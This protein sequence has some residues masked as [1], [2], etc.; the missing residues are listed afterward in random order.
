MRN[1]RKIKLT[2]KVFHVRQQKNQLGIEAREEVNHEKTNAERIVGDYK[3]SKERQSTSYLAI[4]YT[5]LIFAVSFA[6]IATQTLIP[7][8]DNFLNPEYWWEIIILKACVYLLLRIVLVTA[9]EAY[10]IFQIEQIMTI[11]WHFKLYVTNAMFY[12]II[13]CSTHFIWTLGCNNVPPMPMGELIAGFF[14]W[15]LTI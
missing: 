14:S 12:T 11:K 8:H 10:C 7:L 4:L 9:R 6:T 2:S 15:Y 5:S 13:S 1:S 3:I